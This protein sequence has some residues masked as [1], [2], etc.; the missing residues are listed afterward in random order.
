M[1]DYVRLNQSLEH[2][3]VKHHILD[4]T[5]HGR[6][7]P[8]CGQDGRFYQPEETVLVTASAFRR[9]VDQNHICAKCQEHSPLLP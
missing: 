2:N 7:R 3:Q 9:F 1:S 6:Y 5:T 8:L 4:A